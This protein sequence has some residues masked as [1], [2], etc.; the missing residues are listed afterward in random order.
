MKYRALTAMVLILCLSGCGDDI[1]TVNGHGVSAEE[2]DAYLAYKNVAVRDEHHRKRVLEQFLQREGLADLIEDKLEDNQRVRAE[3][4]EMRREVLINRYFET[5]LKEKVGDE[6]VSN[7]YNNNIDKYEERKVHVAH[8][9][10]RTN[11]NM[12]EQ[13]RRAKLTTAQEAWSKLKAGNIPFEKVAE[14]YSE[15]A[16]S[17]KKG[18]DLGWIKEGTI[19]SAFSD[20]AFSMKAGEI[21]E[22]FET[23]F[24]YHILKVIEEPQVTRRPF[25]AVKGEIR[26]QL[27]NQAK[28]AEMKRLLS[29]TSIKIKK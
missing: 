20:K 12:D 2:F 19:N 25:E 23:P 17:A 8:I 21:S 16:V 22:P 7:Y 28:D 13:Q 15:D 26:Y 9:L 27:R 24:G 11:R 1:A 4:D 3:L 10:F 6:A 14:Q 18:G 5:F 29:E